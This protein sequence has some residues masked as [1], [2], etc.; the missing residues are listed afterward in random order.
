MVDLKCTEVKIPLYIKKPK[1]E[2]NSKKA[3]TE[4]LFM[5]V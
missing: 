1:I 5:S 2:E 4:N 3:L